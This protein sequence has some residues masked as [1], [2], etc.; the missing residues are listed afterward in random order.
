MMSW[1]LAGAA[2]LV[3]VTVMA[4]CQVLSGLDDLEPFEGGG[5]A[6]G[7]E[8]GDDCGQTPCVQDPCVVGLG[9]CEGTCEDEG[10]GVCVLSCSNVAKHMGCTAP[11]PMGTGGGATRSSCGPGDLDVPCDIE[12]MGEMGCADTIQCPPESTQPCVIIC[13][14][15]DSCAGKTI[16]CG[17]GTCTVLCNSLGC[18]EETEIHCGPGE[19]RVDCALLPPAEK[20]MIFPAGTCVPD[21]DQCMPP[22]Q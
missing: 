16:K 9:S 10:E 8:C 4:S 14:G 3:A 12:C 21:H 18:N 15:K 13:N 17:K 1:K 19:C 2:L 22:Q 5:G 6:G 20:P 7:E 11:D